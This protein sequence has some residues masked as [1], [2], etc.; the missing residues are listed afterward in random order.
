MKNESG[1][2]RIEVKE[3]IEKNE[4]LRLLLVD[5][6]RESAAYMEEGRH[7]ELYFKYT[8]DLVAPM[9]SHPEIREVLLL[10]GAGFSIPKHVIACHPE[11][12]IDV[13]EFNPMMYQLA[14]KYFYL[15]E[16][17]RDYALTEN[18][19]LEVF[20]EDANEYLR[21]T[22]KCY[23]L[24]INDAYVANR[25]DDDLLKDRQVKQI[26]SRLK[27]SGIY[28][29]NLI[30]A[31]SGT[32]SMPGILEY[33]IMKNHFKNTD[34]YPCKSEAMA[35]ERQNVVIIGSDGEL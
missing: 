19:R 24:I 34:M 13:V 18:R 27:P 29:M 35:V 33:E 8:R 28:I 22:E 6:V 14:L 1:Y 3:V 4:L 32:N 10:G 11:A 23:D 31:L 9:F 17:Y 5:E 25:M 7:N 26:K 20:I 21:R 16:L 15:E 30:T 12:T 2:G